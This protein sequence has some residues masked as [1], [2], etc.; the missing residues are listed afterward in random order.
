MSEPRFVRIERRSRQLP[1][2]HC[3]RCDKPLTRFQKKWC[4]PACWQAAFRARQALEHYWLEA[5]R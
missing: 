2:P 3:P 5:D 4:S 1:V